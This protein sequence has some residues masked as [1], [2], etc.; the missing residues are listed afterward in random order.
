MYEFFRD[1][2][3]IIGGFL[4]LSAAFLLY[5][6]GRR[7]AK[8]VEAQNR[9]LKRAKLRELARDCVISGRLLDGILQRIATNI[10]NIDNFSGD[11]NTTLG[12]H[13]ANS[14]RQTLNT[15]PLYQI[16]EHLGQFNIEAIGDYFLLCDKIDQ[17]RAVSADVRLGALE[18]EL[19]S[20][21]AVLNHCREEIAGDTMKAH[22]VLSNSQDI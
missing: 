22:K 14:I 11:P 17:F 3:S 1:Q 2:G 20:I 15:P 6:V 8:A 18:H 9:E 21:R 12:M 16:I 5:L 10:E 13:Q 4:A 19:E 7:Q